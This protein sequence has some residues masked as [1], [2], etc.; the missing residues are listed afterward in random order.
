MARHVVQCARACQLPAESPAHCCQLCA[1]LLLPDA[2][3]AELQVQLL[4]TNPAG[5]MVAALASSR[6]DHRRDPRLFVFCTSAGGTLHVYDFSTDGR[7]PLSLAWDLAD[8]RMLVVQTKVGGQ[9]RCVHDAA[10]MRLQ[11][12]REGICCS[13]LVVKLIPPPLHGGFMHDC[14]VS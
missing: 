4:R 7:C 14:M 11:P 2:E 8:P 12:G 3:A 13:W 5:T 1:G 10:C 6:K 9:P